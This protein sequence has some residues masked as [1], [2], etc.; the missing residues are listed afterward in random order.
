MASLVDFLFG[1]GVLK[2]AAGQGQPAA[3][4]P[5]QPPQGNGNAGI[6]VAALAQQQADQAL[7]K[8]K[9]IAAPPAATG[10]LGKN[11]AAGQ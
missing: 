8:K 4:L 11:M 1:S 10:T 2:K 3:A 5:Q 6:D 7:K 9:P